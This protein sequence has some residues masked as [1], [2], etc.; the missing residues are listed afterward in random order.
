MTILI[1]Y[2]LPSIFFCYVLCKML[3]EIKKIDVLGWLAWF[4]FFCVLPMSGILSV[5]WLQEPFSVF[6]KRTLIVA[7]VILA[8]Q[9]LNPL[10]VYLPTH[11]LRLFQYLY[12]AFDDF[13]CFLTFFIFFRKETRQRTSQ[14]SLGTGKTPILLIHGYSHDAGAWYLHR[15]NLVDAGFG[16]VYVIDLGSHHS[17]EDY[18]ERVKIKVHKIALQTGT[19]DIVLIGFSMGG[20]VASYYALHLA[21]KETV[22]GVVTLGSPLEGT[23][24]AIFGSGECSR[25]MHYRTP[26]ITALKARIVDNKTIPFWH[27]GSWADPTIRPAPSAW[28]EGGRSHS[29][30]LDDMGH[31]AMLYSDKISKKLVVSLKDCLH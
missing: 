17:I 28:L 26:F 12:A 5:L 29:T 9:L 4:A 21:D 2:I 25:Q 7:G 19:R 22:K 1:D 6:L 24:M 30:V 27:I 10:F 18:A 13:F 14:E 3:F 15:Q 16:P 20:I 11:L 8:L 31:L 23:R